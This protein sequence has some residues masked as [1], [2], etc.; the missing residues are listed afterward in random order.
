MAT[1]KDVVF[2]CSKASTLARFWAAVLDDYDVRPYDDAEI[3]RLTSLG[4]TPETDP[5]VAVDGPGPTLYFQQVPEPKTVK[6]RVHLD[7]NAESL[8]AALAA[9]ATVVDELDRWTVMRDPDGQE[10]CVFVRETPIGRRLYELVVDSGPDAAACLAIAR[11][12]GEVL[13]ADVG[14]ED[15]DE[16]AWIEN[17]PG[18]PFEGIVFGAVPEPK[19]VKN[20]VHWDIRSTVE[21]MQA[22]GARLLRAR[23]DEI[24]WSV[25]ADPEGNEFCVFDRLPS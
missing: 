24:S 6:N 21:E 16:E 12:W 20:R 3:A 17:V 10:F 5:G 1:I 7:V 11:W 25:M 18:A 4:Y 9:G 13:G 8:D 15:G 22:R 23:D 2:D 14:H 19:T